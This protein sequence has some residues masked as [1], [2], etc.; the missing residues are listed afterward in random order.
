MDKK[1]DGNDKNFR[2][3]K[4]PP[5]TTSGPKLRLN[6]ESIRQLNV[7]SADELAGVAGA[8]IEL[9]SHNSAIVC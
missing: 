3:G 5:K 2:D 9:M 6:R 7:I 4:Q 8:G 1:Q